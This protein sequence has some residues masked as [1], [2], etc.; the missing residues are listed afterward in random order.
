LPLPRSLNAIVT[1]PKNFTFGANTTIKLNNVTNTTD[2]LNA[3][4]AQNE[5]FL[6]YNTIAFNE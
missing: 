5:Q 2:S 6:D 1:Q 4:L 3:V